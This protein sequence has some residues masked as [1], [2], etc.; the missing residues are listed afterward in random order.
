MVIQN[1]QPGKYW[2]FVCHQCQGQIPVTVWM[3]NKSI[4]TYPDAI[5]TL[6]CPQCELEAHYLVR[7]IR[8]LQV[9]DKSE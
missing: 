8:T 1:A 5:F 2:G 7:D 4:V 3:E 9:P 6:E